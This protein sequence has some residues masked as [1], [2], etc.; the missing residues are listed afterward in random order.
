MSARN[1]SRKQS[2]AIEILK[3][4]TRP[5]CFGTLSGQCMTSTT[6]CPHLGECLAKRFPG[7]ALEKIRGIRV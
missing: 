3:K 6:V 4:V 2:K 5:S 1:A 7:S